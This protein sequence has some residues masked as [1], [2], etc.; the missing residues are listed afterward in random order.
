MKRT[1]VLV[2][3]AI[4]L[5]WFSVV[6]LLQATEP[7]RTPPTETQVTELELVK[8]LSQV[9]Q[10]PIEQAKPIEA[11]AAPIADTSLKLINQTR[12]EKGL[13]Q[14][15]INQALMSS[16]AAKCAHMVANNYWA[17]SGG[18]REWPSFIQGYY[19]TA[20]EILAKSFGD[21][22]TNQHQAWLNSPTHY[23]QIV[24]D[25]QQFGVAHCNYHDGADLTVVHFWS[26]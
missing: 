17:H 7:S 11:P 10:Q 4:A 12:A 13:N 19:V 23:A 6:A 15:T 20:G 2:S 5:G 26:K 18:G 8:P 3:F 24:G 1:L 14:L 25:Y 9:S 16:S 22:M 21:S